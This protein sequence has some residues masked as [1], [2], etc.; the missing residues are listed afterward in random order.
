M[1]K[2][3]VCEVLLTTAL[4][5]WTENGLS[6]SVR[7]IARVAGVNHGLVHRYFGGRDGLIRAAINKTRIDLECRLS[8]QGEAPTLSQFFSAVRGNSTYAKL[9]FQLIQEGYDPLAYQDKFPFFEWL[10]ANQS[11]LSGEAARDAMMRAAIINAAFT[12]ML[13]DWEYFTKIA[14]IDDNQDDSQKRATR[15]IAEWLDLSG[16]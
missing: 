14:G 9:I 6:V 7:E 10:S 11:E 3:A 4:R 5:L 8:N 2:E 15:L 13:V 1:K 12:A 16:K